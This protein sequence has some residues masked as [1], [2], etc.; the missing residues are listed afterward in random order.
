MNKTILNL[1]AVL[2]LALSGLIL[3]T[4]MNIVVFGEVIYYEN[5]KFILVAEYVLAFFLF[6]VSLFVAWNILF[7]GKEIELK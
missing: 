1:W 5:N 3:F 4:F 6:V 7:K 2:T